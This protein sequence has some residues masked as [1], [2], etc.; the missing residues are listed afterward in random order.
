MQQLLGAVH[1]GDFAL[2]VTLGD[3][4]PDAKKIESSRTN[5]RLIRGTE[6]VQLVLN[7][8]ERL[9]PQFKAMLPLKRTYTPSAMQGVAPIP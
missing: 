5:L 7:N 6:L 9:E 2:F 1:D 4:S 8:Y 3:Y